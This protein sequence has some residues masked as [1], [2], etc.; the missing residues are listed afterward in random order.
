VAVGSVVPIQPTIEVEEK[1]DEKGQQRVAKYLDATNE[2]GILHFARDHFGIYLR[3]FEAK[4]LHAER[5]LSY[6]FVTL[7]G[8]E[9]TRL[10]LLP[11]PPTLHPDAL[12]VVRV[13]GKAPSRMMRDK[14]AGLDGLPRDVKTI[15]VRVNELIGFGLAERNSGKKG[16]VAITAAGRKYL[17]DHPA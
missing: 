8:G 14:L 9:A 2:Q 15:G 6:L 7:T 17:A 1:L 5:H 4:L 10:S 16:G 11:P 12:A 3:K 13:L